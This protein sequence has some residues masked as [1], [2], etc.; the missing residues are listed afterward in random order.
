MRTI[1]ARRKGRVNV[2]VQL[3]PSVTARLQGGAENR[4]HRTTIVPLMKL[5]CTAQSYRDTP[6]VVNVCEYVPLIMTALLVKLGDP[7]DS[8]LCEPP[9]Q[10]HVTVPPTAIVST[11]GFELRLRSLL[12]RIAAPTVVLAVVGIAWAVALNVR[13]EPVRP[14]WVAVIVIGPAVP[15]SVTV[16]WAVPLALLSALVGLTP[17][18]PL[19][20]CQPTAIPDTPF[21]Y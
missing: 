14:A 17:A 9:A 18:E 7:V 4:A 6:A 19:V 13:G 8:T 15:P 2:G 3:A 21:P 5:P 1:S 11:A 12:K 20:T 10:L 16:V